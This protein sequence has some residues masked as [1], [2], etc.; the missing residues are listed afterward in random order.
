MSGTQVDGLVLEGVTKAFGGV[1]AVNRV[2]FKVSPSEIKAI[3]GPNG[4]GKTTLFN[5]IGGNLRLDRGE[6]FF[7]GAKISGKQPHDV[8]RHGITRTYQVVS[9]FARL[10]VMENLQVAIFSRQKRVYDFTS[11][12]RK[13]NRERV[14]QLMERVGLNVQ[15]EMPASS[16]SHGDRKLLELAIALA[17]EPKLLLLDEPT[18]GLPP[19]ERKGLIT[20]IK[21]LVE[22]MKMSTLFIEH[23]MDIVF[24]S[25]QKIIVMHYGSVIAEGKPEEIRT[26]TEVQKVYLGCQE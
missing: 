6:I 22:E 20:L 4:A 17:G 9:L 8:Y 12:A 14:S 18:A 5:L 1:T 16:L 19:E 10:S 3:I 23:D 2:S 13:M 24:P 26:N 7:D 11:G 15:P 25:A 21:H